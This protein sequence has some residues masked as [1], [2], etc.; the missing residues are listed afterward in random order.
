MSSPGEHALDWGVER[1]HLRLSQVMPNLAV[2]VVSKIAS[3]NTALLERARVPSRLSSD[4]DMDGLRRLPEG[5][6]LAVAM[7]T[8]SPAC[9]WPNNKRTGAAGRVAH[10]NRSQE[11]R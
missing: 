6:A 9:W 3:T 11:R 1:L 4:F 8:T 7:P 2:E 10:G 5:K